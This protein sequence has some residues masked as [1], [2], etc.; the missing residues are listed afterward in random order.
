MV[1]SSKLQGIL[2]CT[3]MFIWTFSCFCYL[4]FYLFNISSMIWMLSKNSVRIK[5]GNV[6]EQKLTWNK[7]FIL[8]TTTEFQQFLNTRIPSFILDVNF[9]LPFQ[10][11][12][13]KCCFF[14]FSTVNV[15]KIMYFQIFTKISINFWI[16][17]SLQK[18]LYQL[19][20]YTQKKNKMNY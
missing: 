17:L 10:A 5:C 3:W 8:R 11:S 2:V 14:I 12:Y 16:G 15:S 4:Q 20:Q 18:I 1:H 6:R 19:F 13:M 7:L 9:H